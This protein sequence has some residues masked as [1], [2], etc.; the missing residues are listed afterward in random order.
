[1]RLAHWRSLE[2]AHRVNTT[3]QGQTKKLWT[4]VILRVIAVLLAAIAVLWVFYSLRSILLLLIICVFFCYMIAP[5]V[6][7]FQQ[8]LYLWSRE[9]K[10]PRGVAILLVY[11]IIAA[12]LFASIEL[13]L[14]L[15]G[16]QLT[17]LGKTLP[18]YI[19]KGS[20][21][22]NRTLQNVNSVLD[23]LRLPSG[24]RD[25]VLKL[26]SDVVESA[27]TWAS[28]AATAV[29]GYVVYLPWL[30][31]VPILSFFMLK[32]AEQFAKNLVDLMPTQRLQRRANRLL[33]DASQ[34]LAA[35]IRAQF[36]GCIVVGLLAT[37]GFAIIGVPYAIVLGFAAGVL[38]F[39][40][41]VGPLIAMLIA[42][43]LG[44]TTSVSSALIVLSYLLVLRTAEDYIIYPR[45]IGHGIK[46]H[47]LLVIV[48]ILCGAQ[49]D[50]VV[51]VFL[52]V[53]VVGLFM[54]GYHHYVAY[55]RTMNLGAGD[56]GDLVLPPESV[57]ART[58]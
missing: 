2:D 12:I 44:L 16:Q 38:E 33:I 37:A 58:T 31:L 27:F 7:L 32:D 28:D 51:G 49:L 39:I 24:Y 47:P 55:R 53:P 50:G 4:A 20:A 21:S 22:A 48:A 15:L 36:T 19:S 23:R 46:I 57:S 56:T 34:T 14:P 45:I 26:T 10:L 6:N 17:S 43:S 42:T 52:A 54:V 8:P 29:L 11:L 9:I 13:I 5:I 3:E 40:P 35:Y 18:E 41:L 25:Q 1:M 30:I